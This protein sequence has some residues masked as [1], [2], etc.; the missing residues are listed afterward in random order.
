MMMISSN[1]T[2]TTNGLQNFGFFFLF[3]YVVNIIKFA[4]FFPVHLFIIILN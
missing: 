4:V 1:V 2:T 3:V